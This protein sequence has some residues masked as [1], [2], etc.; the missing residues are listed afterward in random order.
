MPPGSPERWNYPDIAY[1]A[2]HYEQL[3]SLSK[4]DMP[5]ERYH[6]WVA[7]LLLTAF[8]FGQASV[9]ITGTLLAVGALGAEARTRAVL[10]FGYFCILS[11]IAF[12][13]VHSL[14]VGPRISGI[15]WGM[16]LP[17]NPTED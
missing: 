2:R 16:L 8:A 6:W 7:K 3:I 9:A 12:G 5:V 15:D 4:G 10:A 13:R 11:T 1:E 17:H 14:I